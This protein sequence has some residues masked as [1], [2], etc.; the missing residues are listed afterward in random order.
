MDKDKGLLI[1]QVAEE[2]GTRKSTLKFYSD[3]GILPYEQQDTRLARRYDR[4]QV[5]RRM[6][7]I[8]QMK[9]RGLKIEQIKEKLA[10]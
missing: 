4:D 2:T 1:G 10:K 9:D 7:E 8:K 5:A 6:K 3:I